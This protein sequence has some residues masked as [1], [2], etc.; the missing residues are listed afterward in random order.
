MRLDDA[1]CRLHA[2][3]MNGHLRLHSR[4]ATAVCAGTKQP[5][6][7]HPAPAFVSIRGTNITTGTGPAGT[8]CRRCD[9]P[10]DHMSTDHMSADS[11]A[12]VH[13]VRVDSPSRYQRRQ[14]STSPPS[15]RR[16]HRTS[17]SSLERPHHPLLVVQRRGSP[18]SAA[19][20]RP[21]RRRLSHHHTRLLLR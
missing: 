8:V 15:R 20:G 5:C 1:E 14:P 16:R 19:L 17:S 9:D 4:R 7:I 6:S 12:V 3:N 2:V 13:T 11:H 21:H 10:A 18:P